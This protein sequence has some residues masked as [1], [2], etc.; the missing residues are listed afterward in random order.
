MFEDYNTRES[1]GVL[2]L[3]L[4]IEF[5]NLLTQERK[6]ERIYAAEALFQRVY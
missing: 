3:G 1:S 6:Q 2:G 5:N 4:A